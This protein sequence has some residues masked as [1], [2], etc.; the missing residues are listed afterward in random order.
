MVVGS[1]DVVNG[2]SGV[3]IIFLIWCSGVIEVGGLCVVSEVRDI[4]VNVIV[5]RLVYFLRW[6]IKYV[7]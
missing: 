3:W 5:L 2:R 6:I 4:R 7:F 1:L